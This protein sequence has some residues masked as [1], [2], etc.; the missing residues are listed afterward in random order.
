MLDLSTVSSVCSRSSNDTGRLACNISRS[1][2]RRMAVGCI[3]LSDRRSKYAFSF[4]SVVLFYQFLYSD[5]IHY[6]QQGNA[7]VGK[8]SFPKV[9]HTGGPQ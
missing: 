3:S 4:I 9:S 6:G 2:S 7:D 5:G 1:T 8:D